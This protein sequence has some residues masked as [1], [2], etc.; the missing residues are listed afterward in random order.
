MLLL[1][2]LLLK[3]VAVLLGCRQP[4]KNSGEVA[5]LTQDF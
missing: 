4:R 3:L 1:G 2:P 5:A